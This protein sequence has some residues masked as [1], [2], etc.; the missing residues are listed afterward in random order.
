VK[1]RDP[2][3][4]LRVRVPGREVEAKVSPADIEAY[5]FKEGY[6]LKT[7]VDEYPDSEPFGFERGEGADHRSVPS[8]RDPERRMD[9]VL[10]AI[11]LHQGRSEGEVLEDVARLAN[12]PIKRYAIS[13]EDLSE[14]AA[15]VIGKV[16]GVEPSDAAR[17][18]REVEK[19]GDPRL[20]GAV[21]VLAKIGRRL[22]KWRRKPRYRGWWFNREKPGGRDR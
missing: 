3:K 10:T 15:D 9:E 12:A 14:I 5:L 6:R 20:S 19:L 16:P 17:L 22:Q 7:M 4:R 1:P 21:E 11:A 13:T 18:T 8:P 2:N